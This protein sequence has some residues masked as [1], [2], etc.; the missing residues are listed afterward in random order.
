M[1]QRAGLAQLVEHLIC[2]QGVAGSNPATGTS[3]SSKISLDHPLWK[4]FKGRLHDRL[5][6]G[7]NS[8]QS[9]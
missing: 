1:A 6:P 7:R 8:A 4:M 2:N 5:S 3:L 9:L